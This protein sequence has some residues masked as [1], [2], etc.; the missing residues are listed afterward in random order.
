[1]WRSYIED[2]VEFMKGLLNFNSIRAKLM[3]SFMLITLLVL[4][5]GFYLIYSIQ[6]MK[7]QT[8][9]IAD[10]EIPLLATDMKILS[11]LGSNQS[12]LRGYVIHGDEGSKGTYQALKEVNFQF[13]EDL[14]KQSEDPS[15]KEL[16]EQVKEIYTLADSEF[17]PA[18]EAKG[19][20]EAR[21]VLTEKIDPLIDKT[22][23]SFMELALAREKESKERSQLALGYAEDT[24]TFSI[25]FGAVLMLV[26]ITG[27]FIISGSIAKPIHRLKERMDLIADGDLSNEPLAA[28]S[29]DEVGMLVHTANKVSENLK[30]MFLKINQVSE[31]LSNQSQSLTDA[32]NGVKEGSHQVAVT[33]QELSIGS[34]SQARTTTEIA[35]SMGMFTNKLEEANHSGEEVYAASQEVLELSREGSQLMKSSITQMGHIDEIVNEAVIKVKGLGEQSQEITELVGVIKEIAEQTKILALNAAIEAARAGEHGA[36]FAIVSDEV[37]KLADQVALSVRD[38]SGIVDSIQTETRAVTDSLNNGYIEVEKGKNQI[39][40]TGETFEQINHSLVE[41]SNG[42]QRISH[43]LGDIA[44]NSHDI[45]KS[46]EE[47]AA[48]SEESAAGIEETSASVQETASS[49]E[50]VSASAVHLTDLAGDLKQLV[51]RFRL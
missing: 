46:I 33:M 29:E 3:A 37:R 39:T 14:L 23:N 11:I 27:S 31:T 2:G 1:M 44:G 42:V 12:A 36:G 9:E 22:S 38:I 8:E 6:E 32:S 20:A 26:V 50:E 21:R 43:N 13:L 40:T 45:N 35:S 18:Y 16:A 10:K 7:Q 48:I 34:E 41:M 5:F 28:E 24:T 17:F 49:M 25:I 19:A 47:I 51:N 4:G 30:D 15:A